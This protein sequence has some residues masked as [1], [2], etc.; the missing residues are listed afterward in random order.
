MGKVYYDMGDFV[1]S[2]EFFSK[3]IE[4]KEK[5][6]DQKGLKA[7]LLKLGEAYFEN[8]NYDSA[9]VN[10]R[11]SLKITKSF[12]DIYD[13]LERYKVIGMSHCNLSNYDSAA[14]YLNMADSILIDYPIDRLNTL[15]WLALTSTKDGNKN[16]TK[17]YIEEFEG[18]YGDNDP[19]QDN[20]IRINWNMYNVYQSLEKTKT[21]KEHLENSYL[22]LK[23][24][25]KNIK[26]KGDR[27]KFL[28]VKLHEY[29]TSAWEGS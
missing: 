3:S 21:A 12:G 22:E 8:E 19:P 24:R 9:L 25:S 14:Y 23:S 17:T 16:L 20:I 10:F 6:G 2:I 11:K 29:I 18:I 1:N 4:L 13:D 26:N 28:S 27:S 5:L 7:T 15:S